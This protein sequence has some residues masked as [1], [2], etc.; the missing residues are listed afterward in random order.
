METIRTRYA[1][2]QWLVFSAVILASASWA[3]V[4]PAAEAEAATAKA[5]TGT[6]ESGPASE[7]KPY[8]EVIS[9]TGVKFDLVPIP[10]GTFTMGSPADEEGRNPDE[11]PQRK[12]KVSPFWMGK[13]EVTWDEYDIWSFRLDELRREQ[14]GIKPTNLDVKADAVTRPTKPYVDMTF[15]MGHDGFPAISMTHLAA[16]MYCVW[17]SEKTGHYYRLPT[18]AEWEYACRAGTNTPY[19]WGDDPDDLEDYA[20]NEDTSDFQ[21]MKIGQLKPNAW[22]LFDMHGNV[23]EWVLDRYTPTLYPGMEGDLLVNPVVVPKATEEYPRVARGGSWDQPADELRSASRLSSN[24]D[25]KI[26][27]PQIPQS[28]WYFTDALHVGFRV[29]RP[30]HV[31]AKEKRIEMGWEPLPGEVTEDGLKGGWIDDGDGSAPADVRREL[32]D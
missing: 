20:W 17:L 2:S 8:T 21:Y 6:P 31:P 26:Q 30:L 4:A 10:G 13:H 11:G 18:E 29:V 9:G 16:K 28:I 7:M 32:K 27:D 25:W 5:E 12:V 1:G 22:G 23:A 19:S 24:P 14:A 15:E 3:E